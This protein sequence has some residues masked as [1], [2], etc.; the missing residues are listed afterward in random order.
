MIDGA[1]VFQSRQ[2]QR[3]AT[4]V[5]VSGSPVRREVMARVESAGRSEFFSAGQSGF[6]PEYRFTVFHGEY[7]GEDECEYEGTLY[8]I[9]R[10]YRVPGTDDLEL[11]VRLKVGLSNG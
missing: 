2:R 3:D 11:Y 8:A 1:I 5:W 6:K 7:Q 4:G 10:T 9:Y